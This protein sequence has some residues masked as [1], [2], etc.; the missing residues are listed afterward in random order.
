MKEQIQQKGRGQT[1]EE[2]QNHAVRQGLQGPHGTRFMKQQLSH[3]G[4]E[5]QAKPDE[6]S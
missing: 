1:E 5:F 2:E 6:D 3:F 4:D